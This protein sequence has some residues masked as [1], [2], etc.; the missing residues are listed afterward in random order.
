MHCGAAGGVE[1]GMGRGGVAGCV[2][3]GE[4]GVCMRNMSHFIYQYPW[5]AQARQSLDGSRT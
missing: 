5:L 2:S 4:G 3:E 1:V